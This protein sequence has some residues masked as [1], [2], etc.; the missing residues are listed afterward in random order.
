M[1]NANF[2]T[3][4]FRELDGLVTETNEIITPPN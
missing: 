2:E 3:V 1:T 4:S